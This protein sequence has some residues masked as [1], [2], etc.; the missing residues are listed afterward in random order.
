MSTATAEKLLTV[1]EFMAKYGHCS[2]VELIRGRVVWAGGERS[3]RNGGAE[4]PKFP[5]GVYAN[6]AAFLLTQFVR[7]NN[8]G[9]VA[10]NDTFVPIGTTGSVLAPDVLFVSYAKVPKGAPPE[11]LAAV[12]ELVV[13]VRSPTDRWGD[14]FGKI[15]DFLNAGVRVV[16]VLDPA[17][18]SAS[19]HRQDGDQ[20]IL[21][22]ED[23]LT[24]PDVLP[25]FEVPV[26]R[27]FEE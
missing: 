16:I 18:R 22:G 25:G 19:V 8:L 7:A 5:H 10:S 1:E 6:Q 4:V 27:F 11:D 13:E 9:W 17:T 15:G 23:K 24:L 26:A 2:G 20:Q 3:T 12:P 21:R 14:V